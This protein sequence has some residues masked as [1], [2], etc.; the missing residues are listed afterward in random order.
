MPKAITFSEHPFDVL[1]QA[2]AFIEARQ[3]FVLVTSTKIKGGAAREVGSLAVI[4]RSGQMFGYMSNGCIDRD[5]QMQAIR[6]IE[7]DHPQKIIRYGDGSPAFDLRLPCGG[8][9]ELNLNPQPNLVEIQKAYQDLRHRRETSLAVRNDDCG[10]PHTFRYMPKPLLAL[11][12]RGAVFRAMAGMAVEAGFEVSLFSPDEEDLENLSK[13]PRVSSTRLLNPQKPPRLML[14]PFSA[15]LTLFHD[16]DWEPQILRTALETDVRFVGCLGSQKT[17]IA[18]LEL[19]AE[20]G[21][22]KKQ[23]DRIHGPIGLVPSLRQAPLIAVSALAQL[24]E[25]FRSAIYV[26]GPHLCARSA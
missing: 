14:D 15:F 20:L 4:G 8:S 2:V 26:E 10:T 25:Y 11:A 3:D 6:M 9:L 17:H 23:R 18:R 5:I 12:G 21:V 13:L 16:H 1:A 19:L 7:E 22:P 24:S